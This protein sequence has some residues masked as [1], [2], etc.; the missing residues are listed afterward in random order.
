MEA[1]E[2]VFVGSG[3]AAAHGI[4]VAAESA[5]G[6]IT[7]NRPWARNALTAAMRAA[8]AEALGRW[9]R[10][11]E[12]YAAIVVSATEDAFCAGADTSEL[13]A[14]GQS[15]MARARASLRDAY[16]LLWRT[17]CFTKPTISLID[18]VAMGQGAAL[19]LYGTHRV[20]G[21]RYGFA[22][23]ETGMGAF[24]GDGLSCALARMP[25]AIG[26]YLGLTGRCI[27]RADAYRLGLV[28]HC[29]EARRFDEIRRAISA[30]EPVDQVLDQCHE[31][32]GAGELEAVRGAIARAFAADSAEDII[33]E[34][35]AEP[36]QREWADGVLRDLTRKSPTSLKITHRHVREA[37]DMDLRATLIADF[38][39]ACHIL[40]GRDFYEGA[41]AHV[42]EHDRPAQWRPQRLEEVSVEGV[43][44]Y[45]A[46]LGPEELQLA[47]RTEMQ[48]QAFRV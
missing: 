12:I 9:A 16:A 26:M 21:E 46:A 37:R 40:E 32:P 28:T 30:A 27:G 8:I 20:A 48:M 18:G 14:L 17:E 15:S 35:R 41:R 11:P 24:P 3:E 22:L 1:D 39:L 10:D 33:A 29:V 4:L 13:A 44:A 25:A 7:L 19:C 5:A 2:P 47:S 45:F 23:P 42:F 43:D 38:R 31:D 36:E 6:V 34:L